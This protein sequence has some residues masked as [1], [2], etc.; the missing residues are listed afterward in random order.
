MTA[1]P[2]WKT[3]IGISSILAILL[4]L[5]IAS[6]RTIVAMRDSTQALQQAHEILH[7]IANTRSALESLRAS[8]RGFA[9]TGQQGFLDSRRANEEQLADAAATLR[10]LLAGDSRQQ[11]RLG[12]LERLTGREIARAGEIVRLR[13]SGGMQAA[14]ALA[15]EGDG[16][17]L[18]NDTRALIDEIEQQE[19]R[20]V[21]ERNAEGL[22]RSAQA[23]ILLI[24]GAALALLT[25]LV[26]GVIVRAFGVRA[27]AEPAPRQQQLPLESEF[28]S[29]RDDEIDEDEHG[30]DALEL[31]AIRDGTERNRAK[32]R[33][34]ALLESAPDAMIIVD[35][36]GLI[37]LA[38]AQVESLFGHTRPELIGKSVDMLVPQRFRDVHGAHRHG[39]FQS[40]KRRAM[41]EGHELFG[42]R[43][44]GSEFPVE[45]SLSPLEDPSGNSVT[46]AIRDITPRKTAERNLVQT[47]EKLKRSN[48]EL[49]Q[50][51]YVTSHD[52]QEPLRMVSGYTQLLAKRYKGRLDSEAD[53]YIAF[54]VDGTVRMRRLI[55]D[56]LAYSRAGTSDEPLSEVAGEVALHEALTNLQVAVRDGA[57]IVTHG[58]LPSV[59]I[60]HSQLVQI[61]QNLIGNAIKY[62][63]S[64]APRIH[65]TARSHNLPG[66]VFS[67]RDNGLGIDP[68][69][70]E[71]IFVIFQRLHARNAFTGTGL[72]LAICKKLVEQHGGRIWVDSEPGSG[73]TF[74]FTVLAGST[75]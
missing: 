22:R 74:H 59:R 3:R 44:D 57:A 17:R 15:G 4:V 58:P 1:P 28:G 62:R 7:Q 45:I 73:S 26:G 61:F 38:N 68:Q 8:C 52:L 70:F 67:V 53:E 12:T 39:F 47:I 20:V 66:H 32:N 2:V 72:G 27:N 29:T 14:A 43:K 75:S 60:H 11:A 30:H 19:R 33:F 51:A 46:A 9:L 5:G 18:M 31:A 35:Q 71:R 63:G 23:R 65:V 55:Q 36:Q 37:Q 42:L 56:L 25:T 41:G 10:A 21:S 16:V 49:E 24:V 64:D 40:P 34:R 69:Q 54:A 13:R 48:N 50:F 6:D